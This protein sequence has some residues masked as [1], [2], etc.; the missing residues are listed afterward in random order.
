MIFYHH[1]LGSIEA[2]LAKPDSEGGVLTLAEV[3]RQLGFVDS[4]QM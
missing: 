2:Y 1:L 3:L 4:E